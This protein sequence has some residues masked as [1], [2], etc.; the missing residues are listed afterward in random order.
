MAKNCSCVEL[1]KSD[2][3]EKE[4]SWKN[5]IFYK[6]KYKEFMHI[7][8]NYSKVLAK[9]ED[10][11]KKAGVELDGFTLSGEESMFSSSLMIPVKSEKADL[12]T[13]KLSGTYIARLFEGQYKEAGDWAKEMVNF[14]HGKQKE[15]N[16]LWF[17]YATC[18]KCAKKLGKV[19]TVI[20]AEVN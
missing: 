14:V 2:W 1:K 19:Q 15:V 12:P 17:W 8:L 16:K 18:P 7:P 11:I 5:K 10:Q 13:E 3:D 9:A 6:T 20:F 4:F